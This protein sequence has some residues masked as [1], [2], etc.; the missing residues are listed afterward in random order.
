MNV[1]KSSQQPVSSDKWSPIR[2]DCGFCDNLAMDSSPCMIG[3]LERYFLGYLVSNQ[4][5]EPTLD[6]KFHKQHLTLLVIQ[7]LL[8]PPLC[9]P[10]RLIHRKIHW[11]GVV[12]IC[13]DFLMLTKIFW[14]QFLI[15]HFFSTYKTITLLLL[16]VRL[17]G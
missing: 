7:I 2:Q 6:A 11:F 1:Y 17:G 3:Q 10:L 4:H 16:L 9:P 14:V 15:L 13:S 5:S 8:L 12:V